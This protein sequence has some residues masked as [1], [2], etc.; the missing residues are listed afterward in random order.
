MA[1]LW[2]GIVHHLSGPMDLAR[3]Q[4]PV[5]WTAGLV[6]LAGLGLP[7][8]HLRQACLHHAL[9]CSL[10]PSHPASSID[11]LVR[12]PRRAEGGTAL[13]QARTG[14][15]R[16][17]SG[18][19]VIEHP[20]ATGTRAGVQPPRASTGASSQKANH[21][22]WLAHPKA[23]QGR[24]FH[25]YTCTHHVFAQQPLLSSSLH[26]LLPGSFQLDLNMYTQ[27]LLHFTRTGCRG[28]PRQPFA[29]CTTR[30]DG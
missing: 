26:T 2:H 17:A 3:T 24:P 11:S 18:R 13:H 14:P 28:K 15:H 30:Q 23:N 12:V 20:G 16:E 9:G 7:P 1:S 21:T 25:T 8:R 6:S 4:N 10:Q 5:H 27:M 29:V 22:R 19:P